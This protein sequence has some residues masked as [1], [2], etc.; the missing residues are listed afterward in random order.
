M[1]SSGGHG[2]NRHFENRLKLDRET[3]GECRAG[4]RNLKDQ[5]SSDSAHSGRMPVRERS[6]KGRFA[7]NM[8]CTLGEV[9]RVCQAEV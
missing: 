4:L 9:W 2:L 3:G 8:S 7:V 1:A 6:E 5:A